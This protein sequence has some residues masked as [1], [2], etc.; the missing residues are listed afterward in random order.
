MM[1]LIFKIKS[2]TGLEVKELNLG[3]G[4]GIRY[5]PDDTKLDYDMCI[6]EIAEVIKAKAQKFDLN[7]PYILFEPGRS[8]TGEAGITLYKV[9]NTKIIP[10][11]KKYV[12][13]DGS[14]ADNPRFILYKAKYS[15]INAT[16]A[17][18]APNELITLAGKC[19]ES[20]DIIG[21]NL[22]I[23]NPNVGDIIAVLSTGAYNYSMSSNYNKM[24]KPAVLLVN[25]NTSKIIV[26]RQTYAD[27]T[28]QD[29]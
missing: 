5:T 14:M 16:K 27:I 17:N 7:L 1:D 3:G 11:I 26:K 9:G 10:T 21:E 19:C 20:G 4:F 29:F 22:L 12:A 18:V 28:S 8:I 13:I 6:K 15:V 2:K 23:A 25:K 24:L